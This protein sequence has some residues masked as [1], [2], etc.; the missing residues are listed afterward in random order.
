M[1]GLVRCDVDTAGGGLIRAG[2]NNHVFCEGHLVAVVGSPVSSHGSGSHS[3]AT[4][5]E[6]SPRVFIG[7]VAVCRAGDHASCGDVATGSSTGFA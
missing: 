2:S 7:G 4:M 1:P 6:G 5:V 3:N